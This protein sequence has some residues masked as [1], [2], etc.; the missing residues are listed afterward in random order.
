M[1]D[2]TEKDFVD[3]LM[4]RAFDLPAPEMPDF[5]KVKNRPNSAE[6]QAKYAANME[7]VDIYEIAHEPQMKEKAFRKKRDEK[8][9]VPMQKRGREND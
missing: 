7:R 4:A 9:F 6:I 1:V 3:D 2:E 5:S 8:K